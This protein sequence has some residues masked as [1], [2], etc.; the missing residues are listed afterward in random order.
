MKIGTFFFVLQNRVSNNKYYYLY[1]TFHKHY[2]L[3]VLDLITL[4]REEWD[5]GIYKELKFWQ[6]TEL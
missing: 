4:K 2:L 5:Q 1:Y 6:V 3:F